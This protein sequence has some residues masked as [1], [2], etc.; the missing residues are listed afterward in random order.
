MV[1][2]EE[3]RRGCGGMMTGSGGSGSGSVWS[4]RRSVWRTWG[5]T[6]ICVMTRH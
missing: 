1:M 3:Q 4:Q 5:R 2:S 6:P